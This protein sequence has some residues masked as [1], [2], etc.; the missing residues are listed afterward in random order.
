MATAMDNPPSL[1]VDGVTQTG[2]GKDLSPRML[3][4]LRQRMREFKRESG[5]AQLQCR[6]RIQRH[7]DFHHVIGAR[8]RGVLVKGSKVIRIAD[9]TIRQR[10]GD[11][12]YRAAVSVDPK[13]DKVMVVNNFLAKGSDG[14]LEMAKEAGVAAGNVGV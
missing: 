10:E 6:T 13:S 12:A 4:A 9:C 7:R 8:A 11:K 14:E 2:V 5:S 3:G 1:N